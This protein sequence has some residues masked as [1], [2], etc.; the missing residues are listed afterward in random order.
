MYGTTNFITG[1]KYLS[2][3]VLNEKAVLLVAEGVG[4]EPLKN[5]LTVFKDELLMITPLF[6]TLIPLTKVCTRVARAGSVAYLAV[7]VN[8]L[9]SSV[10][11]F[12]YVRT[13]CVVV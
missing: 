7:V 10:V 3:K 5:I 4:D 1:I 6:S 9:I 13:A 8:T 2:K 12:L 11:I